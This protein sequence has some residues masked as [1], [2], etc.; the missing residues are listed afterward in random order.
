MSDLSWIT[1]ERGAYE[2]PIEVRRLHHNYSKYDESMCQEAYDKLAE[3]FSPK[4]VAGFLGITY[5]RLKKYMLR[6]A[7]FREAVEQGMAA[8]VLLHEIELSGASNQIAVTKALARLKNADP[9]GWGDGRRSAGLLL[10]SPDGQK[11][12]R[13]SAEDLPIDALDAIIE[14]MEA[15]E[16]ANSEAEA[17]GGMVIDMLPRPS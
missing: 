8:R 12:Q 11:P 6:Y 16:K 1:T 14:V 13:I 15:R 9:E 5:D 7:E 3:G 10:E 2:I 4:A 17:E